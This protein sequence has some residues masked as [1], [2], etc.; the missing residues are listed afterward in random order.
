MHTQES[1]EKEIAER[2]SGFILH[3]K[4]ISQETLNGVVQLEVQADICMDPRIALSLN[5]SSATESMLLGYLAD[6]VNDIGWSIL[7]AQHFDYLGSFSAQLEML[8]TGAT[9]FGTGDVFEEFHVGE[10]GLFSYTVNLDLSIY[11]SRTLNSITSFTP[12]GV[13]VGYT[14]VHAKREA[15][16]VLANQLAKTLTENFLPDEH[17]IVGRIRL[18]GIK[19]SGTPYT[20]AQMLESMRGVIMVDEVQY[21]EQSSMAEFTLKLSTDL[22]RVIDELLLNRRIIMRLNQCSNN[23]AL[24]QSLR[25]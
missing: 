18:T 5:T 20:L 6:N 25:E 3:Y 14:E 19:R 2:F 9:L 8:R 16:K 13:G 4:P 1:L 24:I 10:N 15:V 17:S 22:C 23:L 21:N 11:D 12:F 7:S